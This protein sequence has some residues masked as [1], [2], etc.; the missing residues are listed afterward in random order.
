VRIDWLCAERTLFAEMELMN[1]PRWR[2]G[3]GGC[4]PWSCEKSG[5]GR[6]SL[7]ERTAGRHE[8]DQ[9]THH[10]GGLLFRVEGGV[11]PN[12]MSFQAYKWTGSLQLGQAQVQL[13]PAACNCDHQS[14]QYIR[15]SHQC[16]ECR[17]ELPS[18]IFECR[19]CNIRSWNRCRRKRL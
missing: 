7:L 6:L 14:W 10:S 12:P 4:S 9:V 17:H 19:Q 11:S 15:G 2:H 3:L 5:S 16:E 18:Y 8:S 13:V 1:R